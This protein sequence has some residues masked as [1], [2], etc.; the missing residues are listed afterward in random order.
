MIAV[1]GEDIHPAGDCIGGTRPRR[2]AIGGEPP[3]FAQ[4]GH[5]GRRRLAEPFIGVSDD[6]R[7]ETAKGR[8]PVELD[9]IGEALH[10]RSADSSTAALNASTPGAER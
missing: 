2:L 4:L 8:D 6:I 7:V 5:L 1:I 10:G 3:L 9:A